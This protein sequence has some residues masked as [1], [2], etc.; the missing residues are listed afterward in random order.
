MQFKVRFGDG[1]VVDVDTGEFGV[2]EGG[3]TIDRLADRHNGVVAIEVP[4]REPV[5]EAATEASDAA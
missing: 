4:Q 1:A 3:R 2:G 5:P